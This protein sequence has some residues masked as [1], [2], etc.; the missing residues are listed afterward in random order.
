MSCNFLYL[1]LP[2]S[3]KMGYT[4]G[5]AQGALPLIGPSPTPMTGSITPRQAKY[6]P[7]A[8]KAASLYST[9]LLRRV[10]LIPIDD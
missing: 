3:G 10:Q 4:L 7:V 5:K 6:T 8:A 1:P 2:K 9:R